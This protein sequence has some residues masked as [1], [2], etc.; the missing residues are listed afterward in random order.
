MV[1]LLY[2]GITR[3]TDAGG[4]TGTGS[5][6]SKSQDTSTMTASTPT[7]AKT[8]TASVGTQNNVSSNLL[9]FS[10]CTEGALSTHGAIG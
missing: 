3:S 5:R 10:N 7:V 9:K 4:Q 1:C 6:I 8:V 2:E